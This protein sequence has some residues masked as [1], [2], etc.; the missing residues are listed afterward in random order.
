MARNSLNVQRSA[1]SP[2]YPPNPEQEQEALRERRRLIR[3]KARTWIDAAEAAEAGTVGANLLMM[4]T[5]GDALGGGKPA[6]MVDPMQTGV[7]GLLHRGAHE[8]MLGSLG[9]ALAASGPLRAWL[10]GRSTKELGHLADAIT[11]QWE[12]ALRER[13]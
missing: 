3:E 11:I 12:H 2:Q 5:S 8:A 9:R 7:W 6:S 4:G 1:S 10:K 13:Q